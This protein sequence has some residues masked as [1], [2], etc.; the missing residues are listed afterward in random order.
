M[1][2]I[3]PIGQ[4]NLNVR[5]RV[6]PQRGAPQNPGQAGDWMKTG[7]AA[8]QGYVQAQQEVQ[9]RRS[10]NLLRAAQPRRFHL[11]AGE[12]RQII[13][14]DRDTGPCLWEHDLGFKPEFK[15][16]NPTTGRIEDVFVSSP[17]E[18]EEDPI[19]R[20]Y[21]FQPNYVMFLSVVELFDP[22]IVT[23]DNRTVGHLKRLIALKGEAFNLMVQIRNIQAQQ[24]PQAPLRGVHLT[25]TRANDTQSMK[26]GMPIF[27]TRHDENAIFSSFGHDEVKG[28]D[29]D[30]IKV[31]DADCVP[32]DYAALFPRP[33]AEAM[34]ARFPQLAHG[35]APQGSARDNQSFW[36]GQQHSG[37]NAGQGGFQPGQQSR[38]AGI[39]PMTA[40]PAFDAPTG[41]AAQ[42]GPQILDDEIP[43]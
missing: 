2:T 1:T 10:E 25:M 7:D 12:S 21:G 18:W 36:N 28:K 3:A 9:A 4:T 42:G 19:T 5:A 29:G 17:R 41:Q 34:I 35:G 27:V 33:S 15:R 30:V 37:Q 13:I 6:A 26:T 32:Y 16:T 22:P 39:R 24:N 20:V 31:K 40:A 38:G 23:A 8:I 11:K 14:L 43:F